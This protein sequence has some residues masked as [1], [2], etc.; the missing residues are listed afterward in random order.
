MGSQIRFFHTEADVVFFLR[1]IQ[2]N[3]GS[4]LID[5]I[6]H[7]PL[8]VADEVLSQMC[9][10]TSKFQIVCSEQQLSESDSSGVSLNAGSSIEFLNCCKGNSLSR[11]YEMGRLFVANTEQGGYSPEIYSLY[12]KLCAY[13]KKRYSYSKSAEAYFSQTFVKEID[14]RYL[15][16]CC[17]GRPIHY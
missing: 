10:Y 4:F 14:R 5:G 3:G 11:T 6:P 8:E 13:I 16:A 15:Y 7:R 1:E 2:L 17:L 9:S 12:K